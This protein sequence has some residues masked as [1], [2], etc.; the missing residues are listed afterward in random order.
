VISGR[1]GR[2]SAIDRGSSQ[3]GWIGPYHE[4]E[5]NAMQR[6]WS[7]TRSIG[8][9]ATALVV[10]SVLLA[11]EAR[12]QVIVGGPVVTTPYRVSS[13]FASPGNFGT[14]YGFASYGVPRTFTTFSAFPGPAYGNNYPTYGVLPGR[15]GAGLWRRGFVAP[16]YVYGAP[17]YGT[18]PV[19]VSGVT[20]TPVAPPPIG[21]Y[22]PRYGPGHRAYLW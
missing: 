6:N 1:A 22:A 20:V 19:P 21:V 5:G 10:A 11:G 8:G 4:S 18:F 17:A 16:G 7:R 12:A 13:Y 3:V 2:S 15:F 9:L 14:S